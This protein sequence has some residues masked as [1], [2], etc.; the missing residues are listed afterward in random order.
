MKKLF[1]LLI[2]LIFLTANGTTINQYDKYGQ[3]TGSY[4]QTTNGY[5]SYDKYGQKTGSYKTNGSTTVQYDKYGSKV[6]SFKTNSN[7]VTTS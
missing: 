3:K 6:G 7:G 5:N 4:K 2:S 1:I